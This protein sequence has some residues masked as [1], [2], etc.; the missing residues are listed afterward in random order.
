MTLESGRLRHRI[1]I[2]RR[3]DVQDPTTGASSPRWVVQYARIPAEVAPLSAREF[4]TAQAMQSQISG[5]IT[6]RYL[7][8]IT[9]KHRIKHGAQYYD[10]GGPPLP[11]KE[12]GREYLTLLVSEV[13]DAYETEFDDTV[14][15]EPTPSEQGQILA[16]STGLT[17]DSD[18]LTADAA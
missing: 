12:S 6:I 18:E 1:D 17:A 2:E 16:D 15:P 9:A 7:P 8:G 13:D 4:I 3:E 14:P 10:I 5:R 11:D